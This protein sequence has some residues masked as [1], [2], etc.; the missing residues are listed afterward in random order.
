[1]KWPW[2]KRGI[3]DWPELP[4]RGFVVGRAATVEDI[5]LGE[6]IFCQQSGQENLAKP[7]PVQI[8][9]YALLRDENG[10]LIPA[11]LVQAEA[12]ITDPE[13][14][15]IYGLRLMDGSEVVAT[16]GEVELQG[17]AQPR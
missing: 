14:E 13:G 10:A 12:H 1:M 9:Q 5:D 8:P 4:A 15:P 7:W 6:A 2:D 16:G 17:M 11:V 3:Y